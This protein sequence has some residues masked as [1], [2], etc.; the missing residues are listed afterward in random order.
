ML[1]ESSNSSLAVI[2]FFG[3]DWMLIGV[4]WVSIQLLQSTPL[5][6]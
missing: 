6:D 2:R 3:V 1:S 5:L 4:D